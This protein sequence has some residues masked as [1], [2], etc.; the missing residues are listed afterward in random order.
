[1]PCA[2]T[3]NGCP[4][5]GAVQTRMGHSYAAGERRGRDSNPRGRLTPPT[6]FPI[7]LLKPLG[8]LSV[9][10]AEVSLDGRGRIA[11]G[12]PHAGVR[13]A[14]TAG[15]RR[16]AGSTARPPHPTRSP[17]RATGSA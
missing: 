15:S 9:L 2:A 6:R 1:M 4:P 7:A 14:W 13:E 5:V 17:G 3:H 16:G 8:H 12:G 11:D 10:A